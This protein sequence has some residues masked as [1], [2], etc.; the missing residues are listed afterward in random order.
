MP[1][2]PHQ[3]ISAEADDGTV[4]CE[5]VAISVLSDGKFS[6][7]CPEALSETVLRLHKNENRIN[8]G[9]RQ[10]GGVR[11][12]CDRLN[13]GIAFLKKCAKD[14]LTVET[15]TERVI[16][17]G[18][19][20]QVAF[21]LDAGGGFRQNGYSKT[22]GTRKGNWWAAKN[23]SDYIST[24]DNRKFFS[25][26]LSA[27]VYDKI[28]HKRQSGNTVQWERVRDS[29]DEEIENLNSFV[30]LRVD[31]DGM[32]EMPYTQEAAAFFHKMLLGL[33]ALAKNIDDFFGDKDRLQLAITKGVNLL[34]A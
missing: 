26:G 4:F 29:D 34:K 27:A 9:G 6:I 25:V 23:G 24:Q 1:T 28:T 7:A 16:V 17:Y 33:C 19:S 31:P 32:A 11:L 18:Y 12:H 21:W 3:W 30:K 13:D 10:G 8:I 14:L 5:K 2:L 20:L 15:V 22:D